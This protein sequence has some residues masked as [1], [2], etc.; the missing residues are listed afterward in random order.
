MLATTEFC[1]SKDWTSPLDQQV[2]DDSDEKEDKDEVEIV[3]EAL[4]YISPSRLDLPAVN[5]VE[6]VHKDE[7][8][9]QHGEGLCF[10]RGCVCPWIIHLVCDTPD[11][12]V[13]P[14]H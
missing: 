13:E 4:E 3:R 9:E 12:L 1:S 6:E 8:I 5:H 14:E 2:L 10:L 11:I 7:D